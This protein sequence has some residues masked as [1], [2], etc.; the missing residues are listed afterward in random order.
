[1]GLS[2]SKNACGVIVSKGV[3][4]S[5]NAWSCLREK[6]ACVEEGVHEAHKV[7]GVKQAALGLPPARSVQQGRM[8][9][10]LLA[11][12]ALLV[13]LLDEDALRMSM[14]SHEFPEIAISQCPPIATS[15]PLTALIFWESKHTHPC[16]PPHP[17]T[18]RCL[19]A[20][21]WEG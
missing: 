13:L 2:K 3:S 15:L 16:N 20:N 19:T 9:M 8:Q 12:T 7:E 17:Q 14:Q 4:L 11:C 10:D 21:N 18:H 1:M 5:E 6:R